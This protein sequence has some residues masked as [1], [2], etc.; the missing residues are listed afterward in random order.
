MWDD[1]FFGVVRLE[2]RVIEEQNKKSKQRPN[3]GGKV[4]VKHVPEPE[5]PEDPKM[6]ELYNEL[7]DEDDD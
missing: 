2:E 1:E 3:T 4:G 7:M 6:V 5:V